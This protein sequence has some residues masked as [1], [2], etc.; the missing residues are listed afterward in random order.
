[1]IKRSYRRRQ[2]ESLFLERLQFLIVLGDE[3]EGLAF[4][5]EKVFTD[6]INM[7]MKLVSNILYEE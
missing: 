3:S 2:K 5:K 6:S 1:M 7:A 4:V